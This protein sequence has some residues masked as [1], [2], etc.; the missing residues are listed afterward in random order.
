MP[1]LTTPRAVVFASVN[2]WNETDADELAARATHGVAD[3]LRSHEYRVEAHPIVSDVHPSE[4]LRI[5]VA[6]RNIGTLVMGAYGRRGLRELL[7]GSTTSSLLEA[8]PCALF[9]YH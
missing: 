8:P 9:L 3:Y 2:G 7:F 4:A 6:D 5:Q 1:A